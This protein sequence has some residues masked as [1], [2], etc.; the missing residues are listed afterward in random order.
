M[1]AHDERPLALVC[2]FVACGVSYRLIVLGFEGVVVAVVVLRVV[3]FLF[4]AFYCYVLA[5]CV[6]FVVFVH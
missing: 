6:M 1:L 2:S 4:R 5:C 3:L